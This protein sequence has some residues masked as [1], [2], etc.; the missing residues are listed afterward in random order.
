MSV[1]VVYVPRDTLAVCI[2]NMSKLD[3]WARLWRG[4]P[5]E[6]LIQEYEYIQLEKDGET[7][8]VS[9]YSTILGASI[10]WETT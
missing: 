7:G 6:P 9:G 3:P 5:S 4:N 1:P 8:K 10:E 2:P